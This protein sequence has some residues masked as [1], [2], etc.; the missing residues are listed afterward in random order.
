MRITF[1]EIHSLDHAP[2]LPVWQYSLACAYLQAYLTKSDIYD[3]LTF[4]RVTDYESASPRD[5]VDAIV[6]QQPDVLAASCYT[7]NWQL[8]KQVIPAAKKRLEG[9]TV[10]AGG[11]EFDGRTA[12]PALRGTPEIDAIVLGEGEVTFKE[13]IELLYDQRHPERRRSNGPVRL[14][15]AGHGGARSRLASILGVMVRDDSGEPFTPGNR[16]VI[17]DLDDIPSPYLSGVIDLATLRNGMVAIE[18]QRGCPY[19]CAYCDYPK[20]EFETTRVRY[21]PEER[22][23]RELD[24]IYASGVRQLYLMDATFNSRR[25]RCKDI[26]AYIGQLRSRHRSRIAVNTEMFPE[27]MDE[28]ML[29]LARD[30]NLNYLEIGIQS[31]N[32]LALQLMTRPR[33]EARLLEILDLAIRHEVK[34]VPQLILGLPGDDAA[35]FYRSFDQIYGLPTIDFQCFK[36]LALPGTPYRARAEELGLV[37]QETP[38]YEV[39][40]TPTFSRAELARLDLFRRLAQV[41]LPLRPALSVIVASAAVAY[42][43][44]FERFM[45]ELDDCGPWRWPVQSLEEAATL[46]SIVSRFTDHLAARYG[47]ALDSEARRVMQQE[48]RT[49]ESHLEI[50][51]MS[52]AS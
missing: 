7:W 37:Y 12:P 26:L 5:L 13:V 48:L 28:E 32:P 39:V 3:R 18:T 29:L 14:P 40:E 44:L 31:M 2:G 30:A 47:A 22:I 21:F 11:P 15:M 8:M 19:R 6:A 45:A 46:R 34:I 42:H 33:K 17:A 38:P 4:N 43:E 10:L 25:Q 49:I 24:A 16:P 20:R 50:Q 23:Y 41:F 1:L 36:L 35:G 27:L 52:L 51:C 9:L